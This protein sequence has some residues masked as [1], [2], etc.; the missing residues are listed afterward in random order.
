M[1]ITQ[2]RGIQP[3]LSETKWYCS[4]CIFEL[5]PLHN[6]DNNELLFDNLKDFSIIPNATSNAFTR[7][8]QKFSINSQ[9]KPLIDEDESFYTQIN[10]QYY[11]IL[12]FNQI[13]RNMDSSFNLIHT[14][15][16]SISKHHDG[17][18]IQSNPH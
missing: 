7:E 8:C 17:F 18:F 10:S 16:A 9:S 14:N 3:P 12:E 1:F 13:K 6:I 4:I 2:K 11:D 15:S 5:L